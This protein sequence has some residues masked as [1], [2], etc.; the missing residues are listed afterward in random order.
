MLYSKKGF[1]ALLGSKGMLMSSVCYIFYNGREGLIV[2]LGR[3][4]I[5]LSK[6][7][8]KLVSS[9]LLPRLAAILDGLPLIAISPERDPSYIAGAGPLYDVYVL[10]PRVIVNKG[11]PPI[12]RPFTLPSIFL[13]PLLDSRL[14]VEML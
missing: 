4:P 12:P 13:L 2:N 9:P 3:T 6:S 14:Y 11:S 8:R 5:L 10:K 1:T 7:A